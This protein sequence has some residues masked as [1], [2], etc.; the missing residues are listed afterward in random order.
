MLVILFTGGLTEWLAS[1]SLWGC[2][3]TGCGWFV[4]GWL[5]VAPGELWNRDKAKYQAQ[6]AFAWSSAFGIL[7]L[8][9]RII[10]GLFM[11]FALNGLIIWA[12]CFAISGLWGGFFFALSRP[13]EIIKRMSLRQCASIIF[14]ALRVSL[15]FAISISLVITSSTLLTQLLVPLLSRRVSWFGHAMMWGLA[16][17]VGGFAVAGLGLSQYK[18]E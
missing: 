15:T 18:G 4:T 8:M 2:V 7:V 12:I 14:Y 16:G 3:F 17:A 9:L 5:S 6:A 1:P 13:P 10:P 11:D